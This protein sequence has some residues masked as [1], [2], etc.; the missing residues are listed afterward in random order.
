MYALAPRAHKMVSWLTVLA[1]VLLGRMYP[2]WWAWA[3]LLFVMNVLTRRQRQAPGYPDVPA[4]RWPIAVLAGIML[5]L[6]FT[7]S[8]FDMAWK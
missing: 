3:G 7:V 8:P 1:L 4:S 6:T 2:N 5:A